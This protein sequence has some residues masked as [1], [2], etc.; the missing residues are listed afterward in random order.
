ME[1]S[2]LS[3]W[4]ARLPLEDIRHCSSATSSPAHSPN[5]CGPHG[6]L[7]AFLSFI[8]VYFYVC[9]PR[10]SLKF[11]REKTSTFTSR[12]TAPGTN[13]VLETGLMNGRIESP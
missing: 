6:I 1:E 12:L 13:Q 9:F 5:S 4:G 3:T 8:T 11:L 10:Q 2:L 7:S